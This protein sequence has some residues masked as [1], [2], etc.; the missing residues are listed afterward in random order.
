MTGGYL[1]AHAAGPPPDGPIRVF[2]H[3]W[4]GDYRD[5]VEHILRR[6]DFD[7]DHKDVI[8]CVG[9]N[10]RRT[11][12]VPALLASAHN[13]IAVGTAAGD[14][15]SSGGYTRFE[16]PGRCKPD[17]V[18]P[19]G[20]TS[21]TTPAVAAAAARLLEAADG[22]GRGRQSELIKAVL[23]A[24]ARKPALWRPREGRPLDEHL[25]AGVVDFD[26][27]LQILQAGPLAADQLDPSRPGG[28]AHLKMKGSS[29]R[30]FGLVTQGPRRSLSIVL[31][32][33][34]RIDGRVGHV[35]PDRQ[36]VWY[37]SPRTAD[38]DLRLFFSQGQGT[39]CLVALSDSEVDNVEHLYL[40]EVPAGRYRLEVLRQSDRHREAWDAALA[41]RLAP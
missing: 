29:Q 36:R 14:G 16:G 3:S 34:R 10:N 38:F 12:A 21:F 19:R 27:S 7:V 31:V 15:A 33:H 13:V 23:L 18:G 25:G 39:D 8:H 37:D 32:W 40:P 22:M 20:L 1:F 28:W 26:Q 6:V 11:S 17:L 35:G 41:F 4:V 24:G 2:N 5:G 30:S 9:V